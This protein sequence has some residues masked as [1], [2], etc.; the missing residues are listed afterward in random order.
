MN[1]IAHNDILIDA[2]LAKVWQTLISGSRWSDWHAQTEFL[3]GDIKPDAKFHWR[4]MGFPVDAHVIEFKE[5]DHFTFTGAPPGKPAAFQHRLSVREQNEKC[6]VAYDEWSFA[7]NAERSAPLERA[8]ARMLEELKWWCEEKTND[9]YELS[10]DPRRLQPERMQKFLETTY[11]C[12]GIPVETVRRAIAGSLNFGVYKGEEQIGFTRV[13]T[14]RA[15]FAWLC[16]VYIEPEHRGHGLSKW[17][18]GT[19]VKHPDL[20]G[21]RRLLLATA[22]AHTLYERFGFEVTKKP[23]NWLE[24]VDNE[25]YLRPFK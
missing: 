22:D 20:Q 9:G 7:A 19:V 25:I 23:E 13:V 15:T 5:H 18:I 14:D 1:Q 24:I 8:H 21:L 10:T 17:M 6:L 2:P 12:K 3:Y 16:D 4:T 11:W